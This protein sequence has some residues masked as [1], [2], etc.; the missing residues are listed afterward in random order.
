MCTWDPAQR[1]RWAT[2]MVLMLVMLVYKR[3]RSSN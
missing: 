1:M 2:G 3:A